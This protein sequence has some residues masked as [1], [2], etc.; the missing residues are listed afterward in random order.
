VDGKDREGEEIIKM[1]NQRYDLIDYSIQDDEQFTFEYNP[2]NNVGIFSI[3]D[4]N[5]GEPL[6]QVTH[7][8]ILKK[9]FSSQLDEI[10]KK[11]KKVCI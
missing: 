11:Y 3:F 1:E 5:N 6:R 10:T 9:E 4:L 2:K 7:H 8:N